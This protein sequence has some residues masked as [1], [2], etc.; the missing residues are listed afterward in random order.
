MSEENLRNPYRHGRRPGYQ[1]PRPQLSNRGWVEKSATERTN[2]KPARDVLHV[3]TW[4]VR[5]QKRAEL[6]HSLK[7]LNEE[8]KKY[9]LAINIGKTKMMIFG[10]NKTEPT[11]EVDGHII[12][13][14][15]RFTYLGSNF[16]CNLD[17]KAEIKTRL[18]KAYTI[19]GTLDNIWRSSTITMPTKMKIL[20]TTVFS[21]ALYG[22]ETW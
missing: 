19:L 5:T 10:G 6:E 15:E 21:T 20:N 8:A 18:A 4:N 1:G 22:C 17:D 13:N 16:E 12:E 2:L 9:G 7:I 14:V 11:I 3:G